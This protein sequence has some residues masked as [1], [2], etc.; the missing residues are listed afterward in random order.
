M[1]MTDT[2]ITKVLDKLVDLFFSN[3]AERN[4][5]RRTDRDALAAIFEQIWKTSEEIHVLARGKSSTSEDYSIRIRDLNQYIL[6][7]EIHIDREVYPLVNEYFT[8]LAAFCKT[9]REHG[10]ED[11]QQRMH[12]TGEFDAHAVLELHEAFKVFDATRDKLLTHIRS[13]I[14]ELKRL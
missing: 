7:N 3:A 1:S 12:D 8:E 10:S 14:S 6:Q 4:K 11:D 9:V 2:L 13:R 5:A